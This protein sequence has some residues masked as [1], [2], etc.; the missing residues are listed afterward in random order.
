MAGEEIERYL[1]PGQFP[2][3]RLAAALAKF[4]RFRL[5]RLGPGA[6]DTG[7]STRLVLLQEGLAAAK[8]RS[9]ADE[10]AGQFSQRGPAG[11]RP[12][13]GLTFRVG[14]TGHGRAYLGSS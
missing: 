8:D 10:D 12:R 7:K 2:S 14:R 6:T 9:F 1:L 3:G 13:I 5:G 11:G 4:E